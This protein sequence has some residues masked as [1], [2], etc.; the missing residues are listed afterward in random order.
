VGAGG[1]G[2][3]GSGTAAL[4]AVG[5]GAGGVDP[6]ARVKAPT[7]AP[8]TSAVTHTPRAAPMGSPRAARGLRGG[9]RPGGPVPALGRGGPAGGIAPRAD[10]TVTDPLETRRRRGGGAGPSTGTGAVGGPPVR[11]GPA[12]WSSPDR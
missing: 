8:T 5:G 3:S 6:T 7:A 1:G 12:G 10:R 4:T 11:A 9:G 2:G